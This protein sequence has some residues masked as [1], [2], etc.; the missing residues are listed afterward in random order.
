MISL[1]TGKKGTGKT[2][3][4]IDMIKSTLET[5]TG[6]VVCIE[7]GMKLT[8]DIPHKVRLVDAEEYGITSYDA[9]YGFVSGMLAGN[10]DIQ[11]IFVDGILKIGGRDYNELGVMLEKLAMMAK[12]VKIT[13]TVSADADELPQNVKA[14]I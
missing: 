9:F 11:E 7:R 13:F 10:Y 6:N 2:K 5:A 4:L 3:V 8:Y 14:F 12:D 1:I